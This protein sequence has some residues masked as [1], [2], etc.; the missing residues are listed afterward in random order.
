MSFIKNIVNSNLFKVTSLNS[1]SILIKIL[2]G[3][4]TSKVIAIFIG[5]SG[6][7]L[8]GNLR[9]FMSSIEALSTLGFENGVVKYVSENKSDES[10][11]RI[12]L[13]TVFFSVLI[14]C[15]F[16]SLSL[17]IFSDYFNVK[18]FGNLNYQYLIKSL[19]VVLPF[20]IGNI[21]LVAV[22]NGLGN[23]K[24]VISINILGTIIGLIVT[25]LLITQFQVSGALF[26]IVITPSLLFFVSFY[27]INKELN[28]FKFVSLKEVKFLE[29]KNFSSFTIMALVSS[30]FG[31]IVFLAIRNHIIGD[32]GIDVA[33]YWEAMS[34]ISSY[35]FLF[36][37]SILGIYFLPKLSSSKSYKETN[38]LIISYFKTVLPLF[39]FGLIVVFI[40][41]DILIQ[42]VFSKD[43]SPMNKLFLWQMIGDVL[44]AASYILA[45]QFYAKKM[46]KAFVT[47]EL[48]S[49]AVLYFSSIYFISIYQIE[50]VVIA[51]AFTYLIYFGALVIYFRKNLFIKK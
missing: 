13:S 38:G 3:F 4:V 39:V 48:L 50:G 8:V 46:T 24:K 16:V 27:N 25:V 32:L 5:P 1:V 18:I 20:Y 41:K 14:S 10:K 43:F 15:L 29:L 11:L 2:V 23:Y 33:G 9:N 22:I 21:F 51:H 40:F 30:V 7:A 6:M 34:R 19:I 35:Y 17:L 36:I 12:T 26:S 45:F 28:I 44:K 31:P 49:L 47:F 37:T 42:L